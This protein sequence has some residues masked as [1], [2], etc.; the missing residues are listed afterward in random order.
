MKKIQ[1]VIGLCLLATTGF[2]Q[3]EINAELRPRAEMRH[4]YKILPVEDADA[5]TFVSQR[6]R[7]NLFY[8]HEKFKMGFSLQ[9]VRVWGDEQLFTSTGVYGDNVS[10]DLNEGWIEIFAGKSNSFKIGRQYWVYE[11]ERLFSK[12]NWNQSSVKYDGLLYKFEPEKDKNS[13][14]TFS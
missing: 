14:W 3:F 7:L 12:R 6:T 5:S 4:G 1:F 11:D 10:L 9:D 2:G 13:C 8:N